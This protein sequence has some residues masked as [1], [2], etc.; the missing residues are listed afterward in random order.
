MVLILILLK[1][2]NFGM[3]SRNTWIFQE[4]DSLSPVSHQYPQILIPS[5]EVGISQ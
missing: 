3:A 5:Q 4:C 2:T 1:E